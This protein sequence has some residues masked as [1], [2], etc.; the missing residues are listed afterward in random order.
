MG[1]NVFLGPENLARLAS[2]VGFDEDQEEVKRQG[3]SWSGI[4][5][6]PYFF[7]NG[8]PLSSGCQEPQAYMRAIRRAAQ[9]ACPGDQ[10]RIDGLER[11]AQLNGSCGVLDSFDAK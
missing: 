3:L 5:G 2:Q 8:Q 10:V 6:V 11:S 7:I 4:G 1:D 9:Q